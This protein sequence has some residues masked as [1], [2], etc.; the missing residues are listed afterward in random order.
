MDMNWRPFTPADRLWAQDEAI[1]LAKFVEEIAPKFGA[2]VALTD[3]CLY[4]EG[5]RKD[6]DLLFYCIRQLDE[7]DEDGLLD[8]LMRHGFVIGERKGWVRKATFCGRDV[9]LF[10]PEAYPAS[11]AA[12][13][14]G[15]Y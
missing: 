15:T 6:I 9:D 14:A 7:I 5:R 11:S 2:H 13:A 8:A 4:K 3:G 1:R 10:F 12:P